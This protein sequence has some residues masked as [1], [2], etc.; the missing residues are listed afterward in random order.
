MDHATKGEAPFAN[1]VKTQLDSQPASR[2]ETREYPNGGRKGLLFSDG[3]QKAARLARDIPRE[4]EQD[5]FRQVLALATRALLQAGREPRP[6]RGLYIAVLKVLSDSNLP[7][8]DRE[9]AQ[10]IEDQVKRLQKDHA[11][12]P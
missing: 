6:D 4:V 2:T 3:R 8:F 10:T 11:D 12:Q 7:I 1:L 9:D 5:I